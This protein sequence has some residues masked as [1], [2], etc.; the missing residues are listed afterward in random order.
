MAGLIDAFKV[1]HLVTIGET[2][3]YGVPLAERN[4]AFLPV[5]GRIKVIERTPCSWLP[6]APGK[7]SWEEMTTRDVLSGKFS[8]CWMVLYRWYG[9]LRVGHIGTTEA[10]SDATN[11]VHRTWD[12]FRRDFPNS[13]IRAF[14]PYS[15]NRD[16]MPAS[17]SADI[18]ALPTWFGIITNPGHECYSITAY[19][20]QR[21][22]NT[23]RVVEV[24]VH[25][26]ALNAGAHPM[27]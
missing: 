9:M 24:R 19:P 17:T 25:R 26:E 15:R 23:Y 18:A 14:K 13:V 16:R 12:T 21:D 20:Q 4:G 6:Y 1:G 11:N 7:I 2:A 22:P 8:G 27:K 3:E 10:G 5:Q